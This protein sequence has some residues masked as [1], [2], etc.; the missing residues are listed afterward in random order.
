MT[1]NGITTTKVKREKWFT[2]LVTYL[3][4]GSHVNSTLFVEPVPYATGTYDIPGA[5]S[6]GRH[7]PMNVRR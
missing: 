2:Q 1:E 4:Y 3:P 6:M 5:A 7:T